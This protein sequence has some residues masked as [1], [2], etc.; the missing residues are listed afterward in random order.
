M[1]SATYDLEVDE[2]MSEG[3]W[4]EGSIGFVRDATQGTTD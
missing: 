2:V 4:K 1:I 3:K